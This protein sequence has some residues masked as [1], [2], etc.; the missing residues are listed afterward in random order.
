MKRISSIVMAA[1]LGRRM[2]SKK[3]KV[4]HPVAGRPMIWYMASMAHRVS[5]GN[6]VVVVGHQGEQV[7]AFLDQEKKSLEPFDTVVQTEQ[8]GTGHAVKQ[9]K[10]LLLPK[11]KLV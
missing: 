9:A 10:A 8:F 4:L 5:D 3:A 2:R 6:V 11:G 7:K 1:G